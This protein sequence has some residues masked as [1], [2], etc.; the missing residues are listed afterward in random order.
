MPPG[1]GSPRI[2]I[3]VLTL[4]TLLA[5]D[6]L[7]VGISSALFLPEYLGRVP[8][9]VSALVAG[10][11]NLALVWAAGQYTSGRAAALPLGTFLLTVAALS[12]G[13]PGGDVVFGGDGFLGVEALLLV[14]LGSG[15]ALW[16]LL[17]RGGR[18]HRTG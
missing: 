11:M 8:F 12:L 1:A 2:R 14:V 4:L 15:P 7:I 6:G 18:Q 17:S 16:W 3:L 5:L 10:G 9:P 13:G